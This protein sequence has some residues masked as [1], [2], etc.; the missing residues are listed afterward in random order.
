ML[1]FACADAGKAGKT[2]LADVSG[3]HE[4]DEFGVPEL[5]RGPLYR[6][7]FRLNGNRVDFLWEL[8]WVAWEI[9]ELAFCNCTVCTIGA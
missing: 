2:G 4:T 8:Q 6:T 3:G 9:N 5:W 1:P 7:Q